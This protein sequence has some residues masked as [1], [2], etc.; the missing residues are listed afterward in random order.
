MDK[1]DKEL[2]NRLSFL[3]DLLFYLFLLVLL[4]EPSFGLQDIVLI[5]SIGVLFLLLLL[6]PKDLT[7]L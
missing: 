7:Y 5:F 6:G 3:Q 2:L 1:D 4:P